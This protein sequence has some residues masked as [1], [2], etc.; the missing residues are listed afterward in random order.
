MLVNELLKNLLSQYLGKIEATP[1]GYWKRN[2]P[3]C[4]LNGFSADKRKRFGIKFDHTGTIGI[5]CFNCQFSCGW[6]HGKVLSKNFMSLL[7]TLGVSERDI[8]ALQ[9]EMHKNKNELSDSFGETILTDVYWKTIQ[10]PT[11]SFSFNFWLDNECTDAGFL[12]SVKYLTERKL[13]P[14]FNVL[15]W[16][17]ESKYQSRII[18]PFKHNHRVVG[19]CSRKNND[20]EL[21]IKYINDCP[22]NY[23]FNLDAQCEKKRKYVILFEGVID[24]LVMDG[25]STLGN[26]VTE[27]QIKLI[28]N[29]DKKVIVCPDFDKSGR[30]LV[31][32]ALANN[33]QVAFP[34][35]FCT[36]KDTTEAYK[37][38]GRL[39][40][41]QSIVTAKEFNT[42]SIN[43]KWK[44][45]KLTYKDI[46]V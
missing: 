32:I 18:L 36:Y 37:H 11:D 9:F 23:V 17:P 12:E 33:W 43:M 44:K 28:N 19:F 1:S 4:V 14:F 6:S 5:N 38:Y 40:T 10:L 26:H 13:E 15:Y 31:D 8:K 46:N 24:A 21:G 30:S 25:I 41:L 42:L 39:L 7:N 34:Q 27:Q 20:N 29:L 3:M 16:A 35:W 45:L 2:C 22:T